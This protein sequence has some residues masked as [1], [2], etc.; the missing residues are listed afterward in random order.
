MAV[1]LTTA[2]FLS[3]EAKPFPVLVQGKVDIISENSE[4]QPIVRPLHKYNDISFGDIVATGTNSRV[5]LAISSN[6]LRI[7]ALSV[8]RIITPNS[9]W[10]HSGS[11]LFLTDV[12]Q[13]TNLSSREANA[14]IQ[15]KG[16][17]IVEALENGGFKVIPLEINA[18]I[19]T[20]KGGT[21]ELNASRLLLVLGSPTYFGDAYDIDLS[22]LVRSSKLIYSFPSLA[23]KSRIKR[24]L[25][26]QSIK[27]K[28]KY[29]VL[30]GDASTNDKLDIWEI[31]EK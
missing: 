22:L 19:N 15:G 9:F 28:G 23:S 1:V 3:A 26:K 14:S 25:I 30:I 27:L 21:K 7:G 8:V 11:I 16:T 12:Y 5:Q 29:N 31:Q 20:A 2:F 13:T 10:I 24:E 4:N 18:L 6:T 17:F